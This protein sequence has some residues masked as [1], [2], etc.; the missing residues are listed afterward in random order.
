[1][2]VLVSRY[3]RAESALI[4]RGADASFGAAC[5]EAGIA[6]PQR[7]SLA[8]ALLACNAEHLEASL[9]EIPGRRDD[10][11]PD[12]HSVKSTA[13]ALLAKL[14]RSQAMVVRMHH[15][16]GGNCPEALSLEEIAR[17]QR[18]SVKRIERNY[19]TA[20]WWMRRVGR[21]QVSA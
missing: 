1:V 4:S 14:P 18:T 8:A 2:V 15:G 10:G 3:R 6:A 12:G 5:D 11:D 21:N 16:I 7:D 19:E 13:R 20:I 17:R 9:C